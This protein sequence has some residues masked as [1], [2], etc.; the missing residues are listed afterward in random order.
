MFSKAH[1]FITKFTEKKHY[2]EVMRIRDVDVLLDN[3]KSCPQV[4]IWFT[5]RKEKD[6]TCYIFEDLSWIRYDAKNNTIDVLD[7][8]NQ[9]EKY[10]TS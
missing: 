10:D 5:H 2:V 3:L 7:V 6:T 4:E 1:D 9:F 8:A